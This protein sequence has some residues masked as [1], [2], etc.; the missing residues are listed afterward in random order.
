[1]GRHLPRRSPRAEELSFT[2]L[3]GE[4]YGALFVKRPKTPSTVREKA[5]VKAPK[6]STVRSMKIRGGRASSVGLSVADMESVYRLWD[7][8]GTLPPAGVDAALVHLMEWIA[9]QT[10]ASNV[11]WIGALRLLHGAGAKGDPFSG[12]RLRIRQALR[13]N[14]KAYAKILA[15]YYDKEHRGKAAATNPQKQARERAMF[16]S[17]MMGRKMM[18][19]AGAFRVV[20]MRDG[21]ID[22]E[23]FRETPHYDLYYRQ[24]GLVD[25]MGVGFPLNPD[26]ESIFLIDRTRGRFT[27]RHTALLQM[28][29]RGNREFHR[30][31]FLDHGLL[32]GGTPLTPLQRRIVQGLLSGL[33]E[34]EIALAAG[35]K[36]ATM[37]SY[38]TALYARFGVKGRAA[39]TAFWLG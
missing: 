34:K 9:K 24:Q 14:T 36:P 23:A 4:R 22:Y 11:T 5:P 19:L 27:E 37:H 18:S 29:L 25:K 30:R 2:C 16:H 28:A 15:A 38:V 10:G 17:G 7:E 32:A 33:T 6:A 31:L 39:L 21:W 35:Q 12:W 8:L 1:M 20:R 13:P 3:P 26:A